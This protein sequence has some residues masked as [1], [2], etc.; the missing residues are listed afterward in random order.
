MSSRACSIHRAGAVLLGI[1]SV[2]MVMGSKPGPHQKGEFGMDFH[3]VISKNSC[4]K[5]YH[6]ARLRW[7]L[8]ANRDT[9]SH[10]SHRPGRGQG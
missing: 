9:G 4:V 3:I 2:V 1:T 8:G 7:G 5:P 6:T 10:Q